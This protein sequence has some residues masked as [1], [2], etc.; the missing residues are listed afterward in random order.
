MESS[1][2]VNTANTDHS[3]DILIVGAGLVGS[4]LACALGESG[5][6]VGLLDRSPLNSN[7]K[8]EN[9]FDSRV[10]A[11]SAASKSLLQDLKM[12]FY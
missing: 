8:F 11:L 4:T 12:V 1:C 3:F 2:T 7:L 9:D 5:Y 6:R 10:V